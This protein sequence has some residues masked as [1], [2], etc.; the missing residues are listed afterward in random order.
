MAVAQA[1]LLGIPYTADSGNPQLQFDVY[2]YPQALQ[3]GGDAGANE[4]PRGGK[5]LGFLV[6]VH[7]GAWRSYANLSY[8]LV[9][10][11]GNL[12]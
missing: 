4:I 8:P 2:F 1:R 3:R 11:L 6:F 9:R 10:G 7:G 5:G 12:S